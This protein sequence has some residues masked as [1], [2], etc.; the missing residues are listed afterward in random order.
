MEI[1]KQPM[2]LRS[3]VLLI[4]I[5]NLSTMWNLILTNGPWPN[6]LQKRNVRNGLKKLVKWLN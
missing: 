3:N 4:S 5:K 1:T 6:N 2:E